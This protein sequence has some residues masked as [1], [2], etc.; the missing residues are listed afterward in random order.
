MAQDRYSRAA[1]KYGGVRV[2]NEQFRP[3]K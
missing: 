3:G 1:E 2:P